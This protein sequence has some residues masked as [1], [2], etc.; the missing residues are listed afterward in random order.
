M[1]QNQETFLYTS[2]LQVMCNY[3]VIVTVCHGTGAQ[4]VY[5]NSRLEQQVIVY[6]QMHKRPHSILYD[7][8]TDETRVERYDRVVAWK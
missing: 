8:G 1:L 7:Q 4:Q 3:I 2:N 5:Y 6:N